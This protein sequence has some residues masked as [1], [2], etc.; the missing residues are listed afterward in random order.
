MKKPHSALC[1]VLLLLFALVCVCSFVRVHAAGLTARFVGIGGDVVAKTV[2]SADGEP[3]FHI[4]LDG[5]H[6]AP[7][8]ILVT[9]DTGGIWETPL[10]ESGNWVVGLT[11]FTGT[12]A[13]IYISQF[14]SNTFHVQVWYSDG[15]SDQTDATPAGGIPAGLVRIVGEFVLDPVW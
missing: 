2:F 6:S 12:T 4:S 10:N 14:T 7:T 5:L 1:R 13:D 15:S 11:N 3:D 9:S 8:H